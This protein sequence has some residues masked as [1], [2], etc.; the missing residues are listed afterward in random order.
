M[1]LDG[2]LYLGT[3]SVFSDLKAKGGMLHDGLRRVE[4]P[5]GDTKW[6]EM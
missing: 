6:R 5:V 4:A 2:G 3:W 1:G